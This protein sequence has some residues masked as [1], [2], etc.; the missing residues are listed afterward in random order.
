M[1]PVLIATLDR[2]KKRAAAAVRAPAAPPAR[3]SADDLAAVPAPPAWD[4][5]REGRRWSGDELAARWEQLGEIKFESTGGKLFWRKE[6]RLLLLG[7]LL[8]NEGLDEAVKLGDLARWKEAIDAA[9]E[10]AE[11]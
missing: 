11:R 6:T 4:I 3:A 10:A 2:Q 7:M 8:E 9:Q 1:L 5:R